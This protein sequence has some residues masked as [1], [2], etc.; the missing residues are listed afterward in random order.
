MS[1]AEKIAAQD[2][3]HIA[4]FRPDGQGT[5]TLTWIW[6]VNVGERLF[7]RAYNGVRSRWFQ[8]AMQQKAGKIKALGKEKLVGFERVEEGLMQKKIDEAY[9]KKYASSPYL[10]SMISE[11]AK[12]A[13]VEI[14]L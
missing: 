12:A 8:S 9:R 3:F 7:V 14:V 1:E 13:T 6:S 5:G 11:R 2:D 4:P 10:N